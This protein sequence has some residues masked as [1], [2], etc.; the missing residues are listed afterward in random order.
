MPHTLKNQDIETAPVRSI[1]DAMFR[2]DGR[3]AVVTGSSRGIGASIASLLAAAGAGVVVTGRAHADV[4]A[5]RDQIRASGG[6][7]EAVVADLAD[8]DA[9]DT[10]VR[11]TVARFGAVDVWVNNAGGGVQRGNAL[12][13]SEDDWGSV[14]D[15]NLSAAWRSAKAVAPQLRLGGSIINIVSAAGIKSAPGAAAYGAAKAGLINLTR[16]LCV[17][18]GPAAR[19]N[20]VLPGWV[21]TEGLER[22]TTEN[23]RAERMTGIPLGRTGRPEDIAPAVLF[24][25]SGAASWISG[26]TIMVTGGAYV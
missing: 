15:L 20:A 22:S 8:P 1:V 9:P 19:V 6:D 3:V 10:I 18:L 21:L 14:L 7:A 12:E 24:L 17:E 4:V 11:E 2:L 5:V 13:A 23:Q 16:T 25:A 26:E